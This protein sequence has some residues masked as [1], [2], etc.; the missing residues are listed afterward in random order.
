MDRCARKY[1]PACA[2]PA[3]ALVAALSLIGAAP[4][5]AAP[6]DEEPVQRLHASAEHAPQAD[7]IARGDAAARE[8]DLAS[9]DGI[10]REAWE[11]MAY[12]QR[13]TDAL[14]RLHRH[15]S[16]T[17][18]VDEGNIR[19]TLGQLGNEFVRYETAHFIVLSDCAPDW[20]R[21]RAEL[22]E[23]TRR[24]FFRITGKMNLPAYPHREKLVC[25]LFNEHG[26]YRS[27]ARANDGLAA[28][29][30]AGYYATQSNRI[31]FYNDVTS[32]ATAAARDRLQSSERR[33][34]EFRDQAARA[35]AERHSDLAQ[36]LHA[37]ADD[38]DK[39]IQAQHAQLGRHAAA[40]STAKTI[41]EAIHLLAFN[42]GAQ[43][44]DRDYPFW[45][46]EGFATGFETEDAAAAFGP[47]RSGGTELRLERFREMC[48][49]GRLLPLEE[50]IGL[51]EV[52]G[53]DGD[54]AETMYSLGH[55]LFAQLYRQNPQRL[56][57]YIQAF[58]RESAG[59]LS[60]ERQIQLFTTYFGSVDAVE[61]R[62]SR[63]GR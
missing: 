40:C 22:L 54:T 24:A 33:M 27:F 26:K 38:M 48:R 1:G 57:E 8:G 23:E 49:Q 47:D 55:V 41:H 35:E 43:L 18:S 51:G 14:H 7:P 10:Y 30:V 15:P 31:V 12:R 34:K 58:G 6:L 37:S 61:R 36:R 19:R 2:R 9:A 39:Q 56:G 52:P 11:S 50:L 32:P 21:R 16:F 20:S 4:L 62:L 13:A 5:P 46:S 45:L 42:T 3:A 44:P 25:I 63:A 28:S 17:L 59:R 60:R 53:W 29:W